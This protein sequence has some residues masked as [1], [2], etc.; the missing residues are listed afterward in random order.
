MCNYAVTGLHT[1]SW[2]GGVVRGFA[3]KWS[4]KSAPLR[5]EEGK[6]GPLMVSGRCGQQLLQYVCSKKTVKRR[7]QDRNSNNQR[8][9]FGSR[10]T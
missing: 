3:H 8:W 9:G 7:D 2:Y 10:S 5:K 4:H 6:E 1:I